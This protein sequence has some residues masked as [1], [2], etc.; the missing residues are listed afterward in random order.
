MAADHP[1][2]MHVGD[3]LSRSRLT[4][5]FRL[6]LALPHFIV[7]WAVA[8]ICVLLLPVLWLATLIRAQ[9]PH[10]LAEL[11]GRLVVYFVHVFAYVHLAANPYPPFL[12]ASRPYAVDVEL[13]VPER[14]NRWS[15]AF[16]GLL[17]IPALLLASTLGS[18]LGG[19]AVGTFGY[20]VGVL[21]TIAVL[22]WFACMV[23]GRM[24]RGMRDLAV[25]ALG[26]GARTYAYLFFLTGRYPD[27]DPALVP[28]LEPLDH[29]VRL[30]PR[31]DDLRRNR[32]MVFFRLPLAAPHIVWLVLW[33]VLALLAA[34]LAW[35]SALAIG[36][37]P[38]ALHRFIAAF[39]RYALTV[40]AFVY[41]A[42]NP[43][44][45]FTGAPGRYP[46]E[47]EIEE[48]RRQ[49]RWSVLF[50]GL[51]ALPAF[52]LV[53]GLGSAQLV[54][55]VLGWF[56]ALCTGRMPRG[57]RNLIAFTLRYA[58]QVNAYALL[59]TPRYPFS[60][61]APPTAAPAPPPDPALEAFG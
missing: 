8:L 54:A 17:A 11:Y 13:P 31:E 59:L 38:A 55:S 12:A 25:Y 7:M 5:F 39:L 34:V 26:Y 52:L 19:A 10:G 43:F 6:L 35:L 42:A 16:R 9:P 4:V 21:P 36:R 2:R 41:L 56:V 60:G 27:A 3:D 30:V 24:P 51:L 28:G 37:V 1:V 22:G 61:P 46:I 58:S 49:S 47:L 29:P 20:N 53:S 57:L 50:R 44:P 32:L 33:A 23:R 48:P 45:G 15:I 14:Q 18:G 40:N